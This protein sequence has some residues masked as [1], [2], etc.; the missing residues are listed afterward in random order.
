MNEISA[1]IGIALATAGVYPCIFLHE[2]GHLAAAHIIEWTPLILRCG[3]GHKV[4]ILKIKDLHIQFGSLPRGGFLQATAGSPAMFRMKWLLFALAGPAT[5]AAIVWVLWKMLQFELQSSATPFWVTVA[6]GWLM[7]LQAFSFVAN[8][9]PHMVKLDGVEIP[10][11]GFQALQSLTWNNRKIA[12]Q[13]FA[14]QVG[15]GAIY[16]ERGEIQRARETLEH[17]CRDSGMDS[18]A[19][20]F[21]WIHLL[22][23][24]GR[25]DDAALA[26]TSAADNWQALGKTRGE[27]LDALACLPLF[28]GYRELKD[29]AMKYVDQ[30]I[31]EEPETITFKGTKGSLLVESGKSEEGLELL[32]EVL[33]H[34]KS[35]NDM[36]ICSYYIALAH[37]ELGAWQKGRELLQEATTKYPECIVRPRV[38]NLFSDKREATKALA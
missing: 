24:Q 27:V 14:H 33:K 5:T 16:L 17:L 35:A 20:C 29:Q 15:K 23:Q 8:L 6:T 32:N 34:T 21:T 26:M 36:A 19:R 10:S 28:H 7:L 9:C 1:I 3:T 11:D 13:F 25:S 12:E 38:T 22:L 4:T 2:A 37:S 18:M 30:A 31:L